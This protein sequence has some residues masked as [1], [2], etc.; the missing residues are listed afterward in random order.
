MARVTPSDFSDPLV[1]ATGLQPLLTC[2]AAQAER[3]RRL[4]ADNIRAL[5]EAN[6]FNVMTPRRWGG[7]GAPL[8]AAIRT[9]AQLGK[10][11]GSSGW[12]A[13]IVNGVNWW[14]SWL[15]DAGQQEIL[16]D[17]CARLCAGGGTQPSR[18]RRVAG[19]IRF[20]GKFPFASGCWHASWGALSV[21][22]EDEAHE[23]GIED[24]W[25][26]AGM[27]GT[28]S[29]TLVADELFVPHQRLLKLSNLLNGEHQGV[30][31]K[32]E[33]SD[34]YT[35]SMANALIGPAPIL[36][37]A[38]A[39]LTEVIAGA[40][41]RGISL[42]TYAHQADSPV[43]QHRLAEAAL[44]IQ[45]AELHLINS[46]EEV[47]SFATAGKLM[48]YPMRARI[49]GSIGYS[50]KV[51]REAVDILA[52]IGG[53]SGFA[54]VSPLQRMWRDVNV[55]SRHALLA[56]DPA[57]EIYGRALVGLDGNISPFI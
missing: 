53:A 35:W 3:D 14:A 32:G 20:S 36:G 18:A 7:Y 13:M 16:A 47:E 51:L 15:P 11:C 27:C 21:E 19:G 29:N 38:Q 37:I 56:T 2:N 55:A 17:P 50:I 22:I 8:T 46:A 24:T 39:M 49:R 33:L 48:D 6:L 12:V 57:F 41:K 10:G 5:E 43:V 31:H 1:L 23:V 52:S 28:G 54:D 42:T 26:V 25:Y 34:V 40:G 44:S 45:T 30:K 9:F 4:P